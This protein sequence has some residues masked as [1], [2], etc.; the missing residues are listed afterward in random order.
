MPTIN[1]SEINQ[2][3]KNFLDR[4]GLR[5]LE[6]IHAERIKQWLIENLSNIGRYGVR[7]F[8]RF[9]SLN[10][11]GSSKNDGRLVHK[12][13]ADGWVSLTEEVPDIDHLT[14]GTGMLYIHGEMEMPLWWE[15][16]GGQ[17][18][19]HMY[20]DE[21]HH[22][23][24]TGKEKFLYE[25]VIGETYTFWYEPETGADG[26]GAPGR[27][28]PPTPYGQAPEWGEPS[29]E[30]WKYG[31][32]WKD[33]PVVPPMIVNGTYKPVDGITAVNS[34]IVAWYYDTVT[35]SIGGMQVRE[36]Q[37]DDARVD[38]FP[39][40]PNDPDIYHLDNE[41]NH[42]PWRIV[43]SAT[44]KSIKFMLDEVLVEGTNGMYDDTLP[45][46]ATEIGNYPPIKGL[47][48]VKDGKEGIL[49]F[50]SPVDEVPE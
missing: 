10:S 43:N 9:G 23:N 40:I 25:R 30:S 14:Y 1:L 39:G 42:Y 37:E 31:Y 3:I 34:D 7:D 50:I 46:M 18:G 13:R 11:H 28:P 35:H 5:E 24:E 15:A 36:L 33:A 6:A 16:Q 22:V 44:P 29:T 8:E 27:T 26:T 2:Y 38:G 12:D 41:R 32:L 48:Y 49:N 20:E 19:D 4:I 21:F 47:T 17:A 45:A